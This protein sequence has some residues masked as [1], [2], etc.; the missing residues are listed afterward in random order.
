MIDVETYLRFGSALALVLALIAGLTWL[1]KRKLGAGIRTGRRLRVV[2]AAA[3]EGRTRAVL[4]RRDDVEHLV[5]IHS[6][7]ATLIETGIRPPVEAVQ[8]KPA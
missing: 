8:G 7:G 1:A 6:G 2:E 5:V 4:I 3:I